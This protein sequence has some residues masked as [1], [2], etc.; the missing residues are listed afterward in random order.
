VKFRFDGLMSERRRE[1]WSHEGTNKSEASTGHD[2]RD[3]CPSYAF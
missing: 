3:E 2:E 1:R